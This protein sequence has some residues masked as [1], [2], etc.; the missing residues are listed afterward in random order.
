MLQGIDVSKWQGK[1]DWRRA[2]GAGV[3]FAIIRAGSVDNITCVPYCD[4][5]LFNNAGAAGFLPISYYWFFRPNRDPELQADYFVDLVR[6][7]RRD[8]PVWCDIE[9]SGQASAVRRFC[10]LVEQI[11]PVGIYSNPNT[12]LYLLKGGKG[13]MNNY[14]LWLA[15]WPAPSKLGTRPANVPKPWRSYSVWQYSSNGNGRKYGAQSLTVDLDYG[16]EDF[17]LG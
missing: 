14:P 9:L 15:D 4:T 16:R 6:D 2:A 1:M 7:I 13:W 11:V 5:Q 12:I 17:I 3:Q 10:E 8:F